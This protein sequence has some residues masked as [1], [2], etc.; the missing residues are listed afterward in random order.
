MV[1]RFGAE[2]NSCSNRESWSLLSEFV[3]ES[4]VAIQVKAAAVMGLT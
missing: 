1:K 3:G 4:V 2:L